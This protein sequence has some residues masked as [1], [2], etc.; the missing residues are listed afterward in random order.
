MAGRE[1]LE[2]QGMDL[3]EIQEPTD[4]TAKELTADDLAEMSASCPA[5]DN[6]EEAV[7]ESQMAEGL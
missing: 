7:P 2:F 5:P 6:K 4:T 1:Q 3:G